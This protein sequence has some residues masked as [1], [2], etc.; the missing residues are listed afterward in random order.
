MNV[1]QIKVTCDKCGAIESMRLD[2]SNFVL[3]KGWAFRTRSF[4]LDDRPDDIEIICK[5]CYDKVR[6]VSR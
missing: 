1:E 3:P 4:N 6:G 2:Y 5:E